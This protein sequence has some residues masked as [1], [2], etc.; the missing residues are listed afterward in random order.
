[1]TTTKTLEA[2]QSTHASALRSASRLAKLNMGVAKEVLQTVV[3]AKVED[4]YFDYIESL[5]S[6]INAKCDEIIGKVRG[7]K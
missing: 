5:L 1:M 4:N 6:D 3:L 2:N 7:A